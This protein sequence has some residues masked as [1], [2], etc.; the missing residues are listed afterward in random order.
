MS[1]Y[2]AHYGTKR[3]SGRYPWGSGENPYQSEPWYKGYREL[4]KQGKSEKEIAEIFGMTMNEFRY[5]KSYAQNFNKAI[6]IAQV[7]H[8]RYDRQM[9]IK[10]IAERTGDTEAN[11]RNWL[12]PIAEERVKETRRIMDDLAEKVISGWIN[13]YP[14]L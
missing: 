5:R 3:H 2:I 6:K 11:I 9:S 4:E 7:K 8:L 10:A 1:D 12:K 14:S 13:I